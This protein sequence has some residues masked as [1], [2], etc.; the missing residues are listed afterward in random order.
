M[1]ASALCWQMATCGSSGDGGRPPRLTWMSLRVWRSGQTAAST[2]ADSSSQSIQQVAPPLPGVS[3]SDTLI[4]SE[5]GSE[6]YLFDACGR[7][8]DTFDGLTGAVLYSFGYD[9]AGRLATVT[10]SSGNVTMIQHD[11]NGNPTGIIAPNGQQ[12]TLTTD[13]NGYLGQ[14]YRPSRSGHGHDQ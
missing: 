13:A 7:H 3:V 4:P 11:A 6:V 1:A 14:H 2:V 12:T 10:D 5:D 8:L 9:N